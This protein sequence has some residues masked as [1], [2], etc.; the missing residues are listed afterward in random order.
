MIEIIKKMT[1]NKENKIAF[2]T[3]FSSISY[4]GHKLDKLKSGVQKYLRRREFEKM[5]WCT[6]EIYL[7]QVYAE[8]EKQIRSCKGI[9]SNL[10]NRL[11]VMMDEEM[12]FIECEK[13]V[14]IRKYIYEHPVLPWKTI[15]PTKTLKNQKNIKIH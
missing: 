9:I 7:F 10:I 11:I 5:L 2:R 1:S 8:T 13:Y 12:C 14:I 3:C 4:Y 15:L 6:A